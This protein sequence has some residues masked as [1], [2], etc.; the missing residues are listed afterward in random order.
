MVKVGCSECRLADLCLPGGLKAHEVDLLTRIIEKK[1]GL[2]KG[3]YLYQ[4]RDPVHSLYAVVSGSFRGFVV[5]GDQSQQTVG[6]YLPGELVGLDGFQSQHYSC[7]IVALETSSVC[8][9]PL[10]HLKALSAALP[11]LQTEVLKVVGKAIASD[12]EKLLLIGRR[13]AR[14]RLCAFL[15]L[16][17]MRYSR[18]GYSSIKFNLSMPRYDIANYLGLTI[19]TVS[20]QFTLLRREGIAVVDKRSVHIQDLAGLEAIVEPCLSTT[21]LKANV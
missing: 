15:L 5:S 16:L 19:E 20:R 6:F 13:S 14:E 10:N 1:R 17:S 21:S 8:E 2:S 9:L 18:L 11:N 4:A 3:D 7:S 12:H